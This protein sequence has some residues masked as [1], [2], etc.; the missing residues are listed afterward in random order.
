MIQRLEENDRI[1][2]SHMDDKDFQDTVF[3]RLAQ[4]IFETIQEREEEG[5]EAG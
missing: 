2:S 3:G 1:V 5:V 4:E